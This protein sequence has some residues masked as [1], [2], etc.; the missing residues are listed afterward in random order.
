MIAKGAGAFSTIARAKLHQIQGGYGG[1]GMD[2]KVL[3][4]DRA[5]KTAVFSFGPA[6]LFTLVLLGCSSAAYH[7]SRDEPLR[8]SP[9][10]AKDD[11]SQ[12]GFGGTTEVAPATSKTTGAS[13]V[14]GHSA[15]QL[16]KLNPD[17][18]A[19]TVVGTFSRCD[20]GGD[21]D[22]VMD[23]ALDAQSNIFATTEHG[24]FRVD[25]ET[26]ACTK[27]A[28]GSYPN[29][30]SF[31]PKGT[32]D[33]NDEALVGYEESTYVRIDTKTG[34]K[35]VIGSIGGGLAS[36]GDIVSVKDGKTFLTVTGGSQCIETDCL[37]EVNPTTGALVKNWGST[38]RSAVYGLAFWAGTVYGFDAAGALFELSFDGNKL[39][40][41]LLKV[42]SSSAGIAFFGAGST[43]SAPINAPR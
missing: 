23:L 27:I 42:P 41:R 36:S 26:A 1:G 31:V 40:T 18:K 30:L 25:R 14:W 13:E 33:P 10:I 8:D 4:P 2:Q 29:S 20:A 15:T 6:A 19:V 34:A 9:V 17:T 21:D 22:G 24:L 37:I 16:Y 3:S 12:A 7:P 28:S 38:G 43:T 5:M 39:A 35:R 32:V 11:A